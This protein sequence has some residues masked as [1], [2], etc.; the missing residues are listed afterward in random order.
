MDQSR[1]LF[2]SFGSFKQ[3]N[4][5]IVDFS[6]IRTGIVGVENEHADHLT[7][8]TTTA[9]IRNLLYKSFV[10]ESKNW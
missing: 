4:I 1:P 5:K 3:L 8:T 7:T 6:A 10:C 9:Q 2:G